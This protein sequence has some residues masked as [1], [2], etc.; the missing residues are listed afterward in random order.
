[1]SDEAAAAQRELSRGTV[2]L[3]VL[4]LI[5]EE[6]RYGYDLLSSLA[7]ATGGFVGI[8][9]G[10]LYPVLHRLEDGGYIEATWEAEG[11]G[12]PRKYYGITPAGLA[13]FE[14]LRTEWSRLANGMERLLN[15][16]R[17]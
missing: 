15:G 4:S 12:K 3:A 7:N 5:R 13:R 17:Q 6:R 8:K 10:T 16:D 14:L 1:M 2:E 11:R 9:E